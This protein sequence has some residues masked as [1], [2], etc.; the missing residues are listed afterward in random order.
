MRILPVN[1]QTTRVHLAPN[2]RSEYGNPKYTKVHLTNSKNV[3][4]G[5][6]QAGRQ[7]MMGN[8]P[9]SYAQAAQGDWTVVMPKRGKATVQNKPQKPEKLVQARYPKAGREI[10]IHFDKN[11]GFIPTNNLDRDALNMVNINNVRFRVKKYEKYN[12]TKKKNYRLQH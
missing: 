6:E 2:E 4:H 11:T 8:K 5:P 10:I 3:Q 1:P 9:M 7:A 12:S